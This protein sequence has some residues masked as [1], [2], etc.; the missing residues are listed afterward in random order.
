MSTAAV[1]AP[2]ICSLLSHSL[3][4]ISPLVSVCLALMFILAAAVSNLTGR[5]TSLDLHAYLRL[6]LAMMSLSM[7]LCSCGSHRPLALCLGTYVCFIPWS[8][9]ECWLSPVTACGVCLCSEELS[10][11]TETRRRVATG[12]RLNCISLLTRVVVLDVMLRWKASKGAS[13]TEES[14]QRQLIMQGQS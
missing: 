11:L 14:R 10:S 1:A 2:L 13:E 5:Q 3:M 8:V 4:T 9:W 12:E 6:R 7:S